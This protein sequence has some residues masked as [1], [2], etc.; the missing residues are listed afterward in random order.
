M[1]HTCFN[2]CRAPGDCLKGFDDDTRDECNRTNRANG[3]YCLLPE[4]PCENYVTLEDECPNGDFSMCVNWSHVFLT[5]FLANMCQFIFEASM[6]YSLEITFSPTPLEKYQ[7]RFSGIPDEGNDDENPDQR[8]E[9]DCSK[10]MNKCLAEMAFIGAYLFVI[11]SFVIGI[12]YSISYGRPKTIM[13]E[14]LI[15]WALD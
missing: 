1:V 15:A 2:P 5:I 10:V 11:L 13:I 7:N 6:L 3:I 4:T 14:F 12:T 9:L 8:K